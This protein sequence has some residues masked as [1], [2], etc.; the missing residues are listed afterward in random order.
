VHQTAGDRV[1]VDQVTEPGAGLELIDPAACTDSAGRTL[2]RTAR[3]RL[4][5]AAECR[6][7]LPELRSVLGIA[8][9]GLQE[10]A[11]AVTQPQEVVD[12]PGSIFGTGSSVPLPVTHD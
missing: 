5:V 6:P 9:L 1:V 11:G 7:L 2:R 8:G 10:R 12:Q 3:S 4:V